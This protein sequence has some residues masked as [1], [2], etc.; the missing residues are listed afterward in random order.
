MLTLAILICNR[1]KLV[2]G[3]QP[4]TSNLPIT[5][6]TYQRAKARVNLI[7]SDHVVDPELTVKQT[8]NLYP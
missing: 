6:D 3:Q 4:Q 5:K 2:K 7:E 8:P 1:F